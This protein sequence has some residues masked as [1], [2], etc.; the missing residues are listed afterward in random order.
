MIVFF[1]RRYDD[2]IGF[3]AA[4]LAGIKPEDESPKPARVAIDIKWLYKKLRRRVRG[5]V[6]FAAGL[7]ALLPLKY[8]PTAGPYLFSLAV[9][10]WGWYWLGVFSAA[11]SA[12]AWIDEGRVGS[13]A[14]IRG[15]NERVSS[16]SLRAPLRWYGKLWARLTRGLDPPATTFD[17]T[18]APFLG[19]ALARAI[20]AL[21]GLYLLARPIVPVAAG[22]LCAEA[23]PYDRFSAPL[24][25]VDGE[26]YA[27]NS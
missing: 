7:P 14:I 25:V 11:K 24:E 8:F 13:P 4:R 15:F 20:L 5:Y 2:W 9:M 10:I 1:T 3:H 26:P 23:D 19:L 18:P 6:V 17:R 21:P 12:H 22:R 16:G 27:G